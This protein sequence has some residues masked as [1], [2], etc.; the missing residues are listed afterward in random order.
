MVEWRVNEPLEGHLSSRFRW[1]DYLRYLSATW[2]TLTSV[3]WK[4]QVPAVLGLAFRFI[5]L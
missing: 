4:S 1:T 3:E 2:Y 5:N